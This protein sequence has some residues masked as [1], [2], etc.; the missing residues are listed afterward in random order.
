[1]IYLGFSFAALDS[2][3]PYAAV[4]RVA[5]QRFVET[6]RHVKKLERLPSSPF[7]LFFEQ[8]SLFLPD[9]LVLLLLIC[10]IVD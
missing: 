9:P 10:R 4:L 6:L 7:T 5:R 2:L 3:V 8:A 1:M